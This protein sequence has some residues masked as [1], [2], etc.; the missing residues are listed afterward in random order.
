MTILKKT[1]T[2]VALTCF[3]ASAPLTASANELIFQFTNPS[4]GGNP[5]NGSFLAA[6]A[7]AQ[8]S[9]TAHDANDGVAGGV[10][11]G[12]GTGTGGIGGPT[13]IVP[14]TQG[15]VGAPSVTGTDG[16]DQVAN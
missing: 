4:F 6:L 8:R 2:L 14:I 5:L 11:G 7:E 16:V 15:S 12:G 9:A 3:C 13:I 1:A 10:G